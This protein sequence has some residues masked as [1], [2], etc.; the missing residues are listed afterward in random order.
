M[1]QSLRSFDSG[2]VKYTKLYPRLFVI[3][4]AQTSSINTHIST[5]ISAFIFVGEFNSE[6]N[7]KIVRQ[8]EK[9]SE[10]SSETCFQLLRA[11][12]SVMSV[13]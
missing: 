12:F 6:W 5:P 11:L 8:V 9:K 2:G 13:A 4:E 10:C 1:T 7:S 3:P